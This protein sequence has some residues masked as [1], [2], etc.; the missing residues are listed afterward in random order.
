M[1]LRQ[2]R[3]ACGSEESDPPFPFPPRGK[4]GAGK[5]PPTPRTFRA[6]QHRWHGLVQRLPPQEGLAPLAR[7]PSMASPVYRLPSVGL[8]NSPTVGK[9]K[10]RKAAKSS[11]I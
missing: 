9:K 6:S 8:E 1:Q 5:V 4:A 2:A 11:L 7:S 3:T 10:K